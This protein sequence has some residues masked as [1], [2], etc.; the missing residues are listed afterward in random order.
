M[1]LALIGFALPEGKAKYLDARFTKLEDKIS[2][3]KT[4]PFFVEF[5]KDKLDSADLLICLKEKILDIIVADLERIEKRMS[6]SPD[7]DEKRLLERCAKYLEEEVLLCDAGLSKEE[8][9]TLNQLQLL[10]LKPT[11]VEEKEPTDTAEILKKS[12]DKAEIIFFYTV[13]KGELKSW[14]VSKQTPIVEAASKIHTDLA[15]GFIKAEVINFNDFINLHNMQEARV[16]GKILLVG[17]DYIVQD[18]DIIEIR[19]NV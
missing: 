4:H 6:V 10:T 17:R 11:L 16:K 8:K 1:K 3:K 15:R 19:F 5:I 14:S 9:D 7:E 2:P 13:A 18:G 12:F